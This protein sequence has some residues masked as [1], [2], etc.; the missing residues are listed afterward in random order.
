MSLPVT[1]EAWNILLGC[2][3]QKSKNGYHGAT[4]QNRD[5]QQKL[6]KNTKLGQSST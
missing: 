1:I 4:N 5:L 3:D 2:H 6:K